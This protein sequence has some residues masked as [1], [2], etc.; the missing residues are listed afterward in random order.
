VTLRG[1]GAKKGAIAGAT[2]GNGYRQIKI[3]QVLYPIGRLAVL[4]MTG[5]WPKQ[6]VD[7]RNCIKADN[8]WSNLREA[9]SSQNGANSLRKTKGAVWDKSRGQY[10]ARIR[11][12]YRQIWLGRFDTAKAAHAA[13]VTAAKR[14]FGDFA[15]SA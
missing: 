13:Y 4:Y 9:T 15:R 1:R 14:Y 6:L 5:R 2:N 11:V 12:N 10:V 8:R 7:H 3:D